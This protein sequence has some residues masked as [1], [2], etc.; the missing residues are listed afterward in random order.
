MPPAPPQSWAAPLAKTQSNAPCLQT[1]ATDPLRLPNGTEDCLYLD[2]HAPATGEGPFPVMVWIHGGA[3]NIGAGSRMTAD[4]MR[5]EI[6][7]YS[8]GVK[9]VV[10]IQVRGGPEVMPVMQLGEAQ[11]NGLI[12]M[13]DLKRPIY[14]ATT[15][16]GHF[17]R[18]GLSWEC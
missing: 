14:R 5:A 6:A 18:P 8:K 10:R 7:D 11:K 17:G 4:E 2:V 1:G 3:F 15:N 13:L 16:Y 12:D 9:G